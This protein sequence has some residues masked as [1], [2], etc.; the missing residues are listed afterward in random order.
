MFET[1][2]ESS[3]KLCEAD[4]GVILRFDGELLRMVATYNASP[5]VRGVGGATSNSTGSAQCFC[6]CHAR[7]PNDPYSRCPGRRGIYLR[8]E[9]FR[10]NPD[11]SRGADSQGRQLAGRLVVYHVEEVRPF[12]DKQIALV[13]TFAD[14]AAIAIENVRL[15]DALRQRT[16]DLSASLDDLR[17]AQDRLV[18]T[19]K[20][21][22]LGLADRGH[23][24]R[25]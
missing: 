15:L 7:T 22:S 19:E 1:V 12:T 13:E 8:G 4:R 3:V 20:L 23:R 11:N 25:D 14:Q 24:P 5:R 17:T 18:Q 10:G 2:A 9:V 21:A 6:R 16:D